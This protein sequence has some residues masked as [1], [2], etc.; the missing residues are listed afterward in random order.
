MEINSYIFFVAAIVTL[1]IGFIWY[2]PKVFGTIWMRENNFTQEDLR[3]GN[4]LKIFGLTYLFSVMI[5]MSLLSFTIHQ[6]GAISM[7][8][9]PP[10]IDTAKPSFH[11]FMNDY[12][13]AFRTFK[14]G[15][16]HGCISGIFF[17][18]P[19]IGING[20]FERKSWKYILIHAGFWIVSLTIMG[21]IICQFA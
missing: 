2:H 15:A 1:I 9:G 3:K 7:I 5:A 8:G 17:A 19:V 20:L 4:M 6:S 10:M 11:A 16:L 13:T 18:L 12:G 21:G 14:H